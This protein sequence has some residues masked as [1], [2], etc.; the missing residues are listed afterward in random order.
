MAGGGPLQARRDLKRGQAHVDTCSVATGSAETP[1]P[2]IGLEGEPVLEYQPAVD[3]ATGRLLG[4]EALLRWRHPD[5]GL[6]PPNVLIPWAESNNHIVELNAWV[7]EEACRQATRWPSAI[8]VAANC[9]LVQLRQRQASSATALALARTGLNPDR[10]TIEVTESAVA[11][12]HANQDLRRLISHGV[13]LAVDDVGTSWATLENLRHFAIEIAKIDRSFISALEPYEGMNRAI[14]EAIVH[15]SHSL[16]MSTVAEGVE[17]AAQVTVLQELG[18]DVAQG[19]FFAPPMAAQHALALATAEPTV[20]FPLTAAA[21]AE[22]LD[23]L[24]VPGS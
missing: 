22:A 8:Q 16:A 9:S 23:P 14:V 7:L 11:D 13:H 17:T 1:T 15:V 20:H 12:D 2:H 24:A 5:R 18:A 10:L 4:F 6:I 3:L 19:F 21:A